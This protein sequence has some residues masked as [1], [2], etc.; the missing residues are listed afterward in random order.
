MAPS[1]IRI[2]LRRKT[3]SIKI[4]SEITF[5]LASLN[6]FLFNL[7]ITFSFKGVLCRFVSLQCGYIWKWT[8]FNFSSS[9]S[10]CW[11]CMHTESKALLLPTVPEVSMGINKIQ[12]TYTIECSISILYYIGLSK[13]Q[14]VY[15]LLIFWNGYFDAYWDINDMV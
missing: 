15:I 14:F 8:M 6:H 2:D 9:S 13:L 11:L 4:F 12:F 7:Q 10:F 5:K 1:T 3:N